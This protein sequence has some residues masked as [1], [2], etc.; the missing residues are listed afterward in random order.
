M[1]RIYL[2]GPGFQS[3]K[4]DMPTQKLLGKNRLCDLLFIHHQFCALYNQWL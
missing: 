1:N 2:N 3:Q 4:Y